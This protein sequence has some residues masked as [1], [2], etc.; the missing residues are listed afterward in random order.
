M[1]FYE[2]SYRMVSNGGRIHNS[3]W[4]NVGRATQQVSSKVLPVRKKSRRQ[5][6]ITRSPQFGPFW[7][8][9]WEVLRCTNRFLLLEAAQFTVLSFHLAHETRYDFSLRSRDV[10]CDSSCAFAHF[11][12]E[13]TKK[14]KDFLQSSE[15]MFADVLSYWFGIY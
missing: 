4:R 10:S 15:S 3:F 8:T 14:K 7:I 5:F 9:T 11:A 12:C 1:K 13:L 6:W 2:M